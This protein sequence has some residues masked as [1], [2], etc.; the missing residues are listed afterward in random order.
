MEAA[1]GNPGHALSP[2]DHCTTHTLVSRATQF[3]KS[4]ADDGTTLG[5]HMGI[6]HLCS[7]KR[8]TW[9]SGPPADWKTQHSNGSKIELYC[10]LCNDRSYCVPQ[11]SNQKYQL[12]FT[13][14]FMEALMYMEIYH[15]DVAKQYLDAD[16]IRSMKEFYYAL[17][18]WCGRVADGRISPK[19]YEMS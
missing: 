10:D 11:W 5:Q 4:A 13:S 2:S 9:N 17:D 12:T 18:H 6:P 19:N 3:V 15:F 7:Y 1:E 14:S 16:H 8:E